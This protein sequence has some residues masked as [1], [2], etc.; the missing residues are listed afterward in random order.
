[1]LQWRRDFT[2][3]RK[4]G[5]QYSFIDWVRDYEVETFDEV[6]GRF[7]RYSKWSKANEFAELE[8]GLAYEK[9]IIATKC[10]PDLQWL[11]KR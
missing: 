3:E 9:K 10:P 7:N 6:N 5:D 4:P 11:V 8:H 2:S 1:M